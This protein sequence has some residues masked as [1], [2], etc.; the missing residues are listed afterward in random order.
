MVP[1]EPAPAPTKAKTTVAS[2]TGAS[3]QSASESEDPSSAPKT[4]SPPKTSA[5]PETESPPATETSRGPDEG[6]EWTVTVTRVV[7]GDTMEVRF[8]NGEVDTLRLLGVDTPETTLSRVSPDEFEGIPETAD[9]RDWL[10]DWG[11]RASDFAVDELDGREVRIATDPQADRRGSFGR[12]LV[13]VY[14]DG[15]NFNERLLTDGYA[16]MYDSS[17]SKRGAFAD[18]ERRAQ[19]NDVGLWDYDAPEPTP[20]PAPEP[21]ERK[22]DTSGGSD[23]PPL[24]ADSDY[25]CSHLTWEQAQQVLED[26]PSDPHR[27]DGDDDGEACESSA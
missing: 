10:Y 14:V 26:Y 15:E 12:L 20:E 18:A 13:Y 5:S 24:P 25:D 3:D 4:S 19:R 27:L 7:D 16:R 9:G 8:P 22:T 23:L 11:E 1:F 17:F 21:T 2:N 6:T